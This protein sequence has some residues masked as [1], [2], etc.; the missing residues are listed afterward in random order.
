MKKRNKLALLLLSLLV[1]S[2]AHTGS[3]R[4]IDVTIC[5]IEYLF[6]NGKTYEV[7]CN[8]PDYSDSHFGLDDERVSKLVC[9]PH[10]D[11]TRL[12]LEVKKE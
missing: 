2:C 11:Y 3:G 12:L 7:K 1:S 6:E 4:G 5:S 8:H 9:I 10:T